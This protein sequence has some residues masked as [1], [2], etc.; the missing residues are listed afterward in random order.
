MIRSNVI[1]QSAKGKPCALQIA[2]VRFHDPETTVLCH[3]KFPGMHGMGLK[4]NDVGASVYGCFHC[5]AI[6]DGYKLPKEEYWF[7]L[8]R[9]IARTVQSMYDE[10]LISIKGDRS[11]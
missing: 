6:I 2:D 5:H 4:P 10:G 9:G 7:Y 8:A 11:D 1:R 3:V